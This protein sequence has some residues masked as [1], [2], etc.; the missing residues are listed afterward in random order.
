VVSAALMV[1]VLIQIRYPRAVD[2]TEEPVKA[3]GDLLLNANSAT[4][5]KNVGSKGKKSTGEITSGQASGVDHAFAQISP[6]ENPSSQMEAAAST[7]TP[8]VASNPEMNHTKALANA[9]TWFPADR[10]H[11]M[12]VIRP[13]NPNA[14]YRSSLGPM[15]V[16]VKMRLIALW[17]KTLM[18]S[19]KSRSST[20]SSN[21][22]RGER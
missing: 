1:A 16:D 5:F 4:L 20:I 12:P 13:K 6:T 19:E 11:S 3:G 14:K 18:R 8:V 17:H 10:R 21:W 9:N 2:L 15:F 22:N 7:L